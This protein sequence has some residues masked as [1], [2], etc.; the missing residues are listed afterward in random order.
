[1]IT[2]I[3]LSNFRA[4][5]EPVT[6]RFRPITVLVGRNSAGKSTLIKFL[7]M[8]RQSLASADDAFF[9]TEGQHVQLGAFRDLRNRS[10]KRRTFDFKICVKTHDVPPH[11][12]VSAWQG[13]SKGKV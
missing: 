6:V 8:I 11:E 3:T 4:Y 12:I 2:E 1:M 5:S 9:V 13:I 10:C 7:Q